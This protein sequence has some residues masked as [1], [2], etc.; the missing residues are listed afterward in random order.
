MVLH[1]LGKK[2]WNVYNHDNVE[3]VR[4]DEAEAQAKVE[5]EEQRMQQ[6]DAARRTAILR[7][8]RPAQEPSPSPVAETK[9]GRRRSEDVR[10]RKRRRLRGEDETDRDLRYAREDAQAGQ[11]AKQVLLKRDA[12][13]G[14]LHDRNGHLQLISAPDEK[15]IRKIGNAAD[16][17]AKKGKSQDEPQGMRFSDAAGYKTSIGQPWYATSAQIRTMGHATVVLADV[18]EKDVWG[19]EDP[20]RKQREQDRI[21]GNDPFAAMQQAQRQLKQSHRDR[22]KWEKERVVEMEELR[23]AEKKRRRKDEKMRRDGDLDSLDG[24]SLDAGDSRRERR[25]SDRDRR[26]KHRH[27]DSSHNRRCRIDAS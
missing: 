22:D 9:V 10:P 21:S 25:H 14:P 4:R 18:T 26:H 23:R 8:E 17:E 24:F 2:S 13:D 1:L 15:N 19:N 5:A 27:R 7:G 3:R 20:R 11:R 16:L 12:E 6:V